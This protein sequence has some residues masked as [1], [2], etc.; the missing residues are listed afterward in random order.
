MSPRFESIKQSIKNQIISKT[1]PIDRE[2]AALVI[3]TLTA[4]ELKTIVAQNR[5]KPFLKKP[6]FAR[7]ALRASSKTGGMRK[8]TAK[9]SRKHSRK[10][11]SRR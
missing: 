10:T 5:S 7:S 3:D 4:S 8:K 2:K 11:K 1:H 9:R 6:N